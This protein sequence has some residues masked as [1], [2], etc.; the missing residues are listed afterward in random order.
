MLISNGCSRIS[1]IEMN[2]ESEFR[3]RPYGEG[4]HTFD[5]D[6]LRMASGVPTL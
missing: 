1:D 5:I 4:A 3:M 6:A 2:P